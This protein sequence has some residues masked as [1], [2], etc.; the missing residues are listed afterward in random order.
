MR[1]STVQSVGEQKL[2]PGNLNSQHANVISQWFASSKVIHLFHDT[3]NNTLHLFAG[4]QIVRS[5]ERPNSSPCA[6]KAS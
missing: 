2:L 6:L 1:T 5:S 4:F 3:I